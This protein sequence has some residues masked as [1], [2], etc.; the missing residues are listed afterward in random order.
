MA[1]QLT[2]A[3]RC[4]KAIR[5][6]LKVMGVKA[7]SCRSE[8][9]SMGD[10][11]RVEILDATPE[12]REM[13]E[14]LRY[15]YRAGSFNSMEDM[16]EYHRTNDGLP[17]AKFVFIEFSYSDEMKQ[18]AWNYLITEFPGNFADAPRNQ[19][20]AQNYRDNRLDEYGGRMIYQVLNDSWM[21]HSN[22]TRFWGNEHLY[23]DYPIAVREEDQG[24][25]GFADFVDSETIEE[26]QG[27]YGFADFV[28]CEIVEVTTPEQMLTDEEQVEIAINILKSRMTDTELNIFRVMTEIARMRDEVLEGGELNITRMIEACNT[29]MPLLERKQRMNSRR[30]NRRVIS[31]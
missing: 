28:D 20:D 19:R 17:K 4:A 7:E 15:K 21:R 26:D 22:V 16:Y 13:V 2:E 14:P 25:Y 5:A 3:A 29:V 23:P 12:I 1:R 10:S 18:R 27:K 9:Y 24:K 6:E 30:R 8:N 11:V 31:S